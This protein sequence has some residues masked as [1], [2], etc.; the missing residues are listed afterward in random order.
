MI[1]TSSSDIGGHSLS[2]RIFNHVASEINKKYHVDVSKNARYTARL[3]A[4]IAKAKTILGT[5]PETAVNVSLSEEVRITVSL[6]LI[7]RMRA[8]L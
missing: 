8:S 7:P 4:A 3:Y 2:E 1:F 6:V 5:V